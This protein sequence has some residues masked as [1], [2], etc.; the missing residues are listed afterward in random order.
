MDTKE[1]RRLNILTKPILPLLVKTAIPTIIGMLI[2]VIYNLTDTFFVGRLHNSAMIAAIGVVFSFAGI[3]QALGFWFGYGSGNVMSKKIGAQDYAEA[4]IISSIGIVLAIAIGVALAIAA[5]IFV[6]P[7][8]KRI[9]GNA[10][11]DV[12]IFTVQYL[13][14]I[15]ISVPFSLYAV[16]LY[17][18]LRLCGNVRDGMIGLL[19]GMLSNMALDPLLMFTLNMGFIGAGY[20]TLIGQIIGCIVLTALA[21]RHGNIPVSIKKA[22]YSKAR[23][24]HILAGG[25]PNFSRQAITSVALVLL[26][27]TAAHYG[28]SMIAALTISSKIVAV[29]YM[30][31]IGWGQGFQPICA[32]NYGA[33]KYS[34]VKKAFITTVSAGTIFL[35]IAAIILFILAE[36]CIHLMSNDHDVISTGVT[37]LKMQCFSMPLLGVF[38]VSS[39]FMQNIGNYG[40]ALLISISRQGL[41]YVPLVYLLPAIYGK[42]GIYLVQPLSDVLSF[43]LAVAVMYRWYKKRDFKRLCE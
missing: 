29:A 40:A 22:R 7:L 34:R 15:I 12:L 23:I 3:I 25:L 8:A 43:V 36:Q 16:T 30:I 2:S 32:M 13:R 4:E 33:K 37:I 20:A 42:T 28:E 6:V 10:S 9:G 11:H 19:S 27:V 39:M 31:M 41:F 5:S 21:K 35:I 14:I 26:N 38:A 17:N 24:Y 18:Q 1:Q